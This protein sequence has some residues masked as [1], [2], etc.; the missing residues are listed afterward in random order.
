M[1][2]RLCDLG[3]RHQHVSSGRP[4]GLH[5]GVQQVQAAQLEHGDVCGIGVHSCRAGRADVVS[6]GEEGEEV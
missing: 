2:A 3:F 5:V 6:G 1:E 4:F